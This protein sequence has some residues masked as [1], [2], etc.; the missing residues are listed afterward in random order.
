MLSAQIASAI[1]VVIQIGRQA[2]GR[3]RLLSLSEVVGMEGP[4]ITMQEIF[5]FKMAG[6]G[7]DGSVLGHFEAT[8][9]R[10]KFLQDAADYGIDLSAELFRPSLRLGGI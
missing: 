9:I 8:G 4:T 6:R 2:D 3:R 10:P 7:E 5:R 1:N